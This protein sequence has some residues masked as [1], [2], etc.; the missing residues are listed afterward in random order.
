MQQAEKRKGLGEWGAVFKN[1]FNNMKRKVQGKSGRWALLKKNM[2]IKQSEQEEVVEGGERLQREVI[3][4]EK[5]WK[6]GGS[7]RAAGLSQ[8]AWHWAASAWA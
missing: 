8:V 3:S 4:I 7:A 2:S 6:G 5:R 1:V